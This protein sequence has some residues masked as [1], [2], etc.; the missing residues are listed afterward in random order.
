[1][2]LLGLDHVVLR[3][4]DL[5]RMTR[6]YVDVLGCPVERRLESVGM[7]Q[8]RAGG[9]LIDLVDASGTIGRARGAPPGESGPNMDH[10]CVRVD[11]FDEPALR[12]HLAEHGVQAGE[13]AMR[14]GAD[15]NGPSLYIDDPEGNTIELKGPPGD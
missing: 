4:R 2:K 13:I 8:L 15:G 6:F 1:M 14:Y 10:F 11:P 9:S 3:V 7:V 5:E 12:A